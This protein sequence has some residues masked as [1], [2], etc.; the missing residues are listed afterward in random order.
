TAMLE[1]LLR[2][3]EEAKALWRLGRSYVRLGEEKKRKKERIRLFTL[4]EKTIEKSIALDP[5][6][7]QAH[8]WAGLALGRRGQA[9]GML[10]SLFMIKPLKKRMRRVMELDPKHGGAHHVLGQMYR[11]L[12]RL[13]GGSREAA[14]REL[15]SAVRLSPGFT[16]NY[17]ALAE[18]YIKLGEKGK[19]RQVLEAFSRVK[20]PDDPAVYEGHR[21]DV[22]RLLSEL[23]PKTG[24]AAAGE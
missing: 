2:E 19:A 21:E 1:S 18:A 3:K 22:E 9:R 24:S 16:A 8:F 12:P 6:D 23:G 11:Q 14:V 13:I 4:A 15:L 17:P 10:Q 7:A 5:S 20:T